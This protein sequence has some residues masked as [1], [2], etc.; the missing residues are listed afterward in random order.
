VELRSK[1]IEK[2]IRSDGMGYHFLKSAI[3][4]LAK[5][6]KSTDEQTIETSLH[7]AGYIE[8]RKRS[9]QAKTLLAASPKEKSEESYF[10]RWTDVVDKLGDVA[11]SDLANYVAHRR[12]I[13]DLVEEVLKTTPEGH[14]RREEVIHSIVFPKGKQ[15]GEVGYE[16]QNLWLI[17]ERL[18][19]HEHLFS[20]VSVKRI[21]KGEVDALTRPDLAIY[22]S[23]FASFYD[24]GKPPAQLVLVELKQPARRDASRDDPVSKT[25]LYV[26]QLKSGQARTEGGAVID[27]EP[28]A[29][30]TVYILADWTADFQAYLRREDFKRMP[31]DVGQYTYRSEEK[32]MFIAMS[33]DRLVETARRRNRIFFRK[34]GIEQ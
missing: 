19:F 34:L 23:G 11:K 20:D 27:I 3:P 29:L 7:A 4:E 8:R 16:Q 5:T 10:T 9:D 21:T 2:Y 15:S 12:V 1:A 13:I 17:D 14:H 18:A 22:E 6:L 32:I 31:G 24:G 30:T 26:E 33:F 28:H 25:L